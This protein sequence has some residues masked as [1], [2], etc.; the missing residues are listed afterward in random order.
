MVLLI[1]LAAALIAFLVSITIVLFFIGPTILL[2]PRRRTSEFYRKSGLPTN[3]SELGIKY[4]EIN[5]ITNDGYR[6][7]S[8][9]VKSQQPTKGTIIYLHGVADCKI[10]GIRFAKLMHDRHYNVFL[11]DSRRHGESEG[12]YCTY[13]Y[14]EKNDVISIIDYLTTRTD[15]SL[16][17]IGLFGTS[18]GAAVGIQAAALDQ[19]ISAVVSENSFSTLRK[20]FDDYQKRMVK[21]P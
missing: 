14:Y 1:A 12:V 15:V 16:G 17:K 21:L 8:W 13:G 11:F 10:D 6:L 20:I 9:L 18:M 2:Q 5:V 4:E 19:R 7:N 3:P